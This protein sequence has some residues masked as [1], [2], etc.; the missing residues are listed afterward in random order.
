MMTLQYTQVRARSSSRMPCRGP[1]AH[2]TTPGGQG[3]TVLYVVSSPRCSGACGEEVQWSRIWRRA[4]E[5]VQ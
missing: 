4:G 5:E 1:F 2:T 3:P